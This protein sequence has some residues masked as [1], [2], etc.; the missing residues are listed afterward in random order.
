MKR[1]VVPKYMHRELR[2]LKRRR[3]EGNEDGLGASHRVLVYNNKDKAATD[4]YRYIV[5]L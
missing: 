3:R 1:R 4:Y 2:Q 5:R